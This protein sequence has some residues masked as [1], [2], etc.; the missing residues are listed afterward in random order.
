RLRLEVEEDEE[1]HPHDHRSH[2]QRSHRQPPQ[3]HE[4]AATHS[5]SRPPV[6]RSTSLRQAIDARRL[7]SSHRALTRPPPATAPE[8][9][10][11]GARG[12]LVRSGGTSR[13][14]A[15]VP[16]ATAGTVAITTT[17]MIARSVRWPSH[18]SASGIHAIAGTAKS[19][20]ITLPRVRC[21][22]TDPATA[23][24]IRVPKT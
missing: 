24:P 5:V 7:S 19:A 3:G 1:E 8:P 11:P 4:T 10:V 20:L 9:A 13:T 6:F 16:I 15:A 12:A 18:R 17:R 14:A 21:T 2:K 22:R 23:R